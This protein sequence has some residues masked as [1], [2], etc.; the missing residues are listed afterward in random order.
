VLAAGIVGLRDAKRWARSL[1]AAFA[2]A[3]RVA[4]GCSDLGLF[5]ALIDGYRASGLLLK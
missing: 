1:F 3:Q 4:R 2:G 5:D